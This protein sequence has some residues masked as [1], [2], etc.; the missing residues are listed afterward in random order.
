[1]AAA[2]ANHIATFVWEHLEHAPCSPDLAPS[3]FH[4]FPTL[5][6]TFEGRHFTTNEDT[7]A[8]VQ[9]QNTDFYQT[10]VLQVHEA[11]GQMHAC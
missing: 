7:E 4:F 6:K 10:G 8:A 9:T 3:D 11:V 5:K 2:M 1:M